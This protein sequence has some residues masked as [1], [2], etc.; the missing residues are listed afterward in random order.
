MKTEWLYLCPAFSIVFGLFLER[1]KA[2]NRAF[3][4]HTAQKSIYSNLK[5]RLVEIAKLRTTRPGHCAFKRVTRGL[6][7]VTS[8]EVEKFRLK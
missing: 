3:K 2:F 6:P 5:G 4:R 7:G 8:K 1:N